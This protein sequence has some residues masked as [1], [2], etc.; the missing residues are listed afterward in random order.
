MAKLKTRKALLKR[1]KITGRGKIL[2]R[3]ARQDHFNA[4]DPGQ[5]TQAK[6]QSR[7]I[8][9]TSKRIFKNIPLFLMTNYND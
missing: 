4:K 8:S 7:K 5:K 6:R 1:I 2:R 9:P 3:P